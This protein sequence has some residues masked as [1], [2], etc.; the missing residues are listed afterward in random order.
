MMEKFEDGKQC[1]ECLTEDSIV[2]IEY[3]YPG[4]EMREK[5]ERGE[6]KLGGCT[7]DDKNPDYHCK[8]WFQ[9]L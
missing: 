2:K 7:F 5:Y 9:F 3:G 1:P 8:K 6:I 4:N